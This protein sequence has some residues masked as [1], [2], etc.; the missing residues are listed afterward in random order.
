MIIEI[1]LGVALGLFLYANWRGLLA[2][3]TLISLFLLLLVLAGVTLWALYSGL[4]AVRALPPLLEP[5]SLTST[6]VA[7]VFGVLLNILF[8]FAAGSIIEERLH[9][10]SR[11]AYVLG[12]AFYVLFL[13]SALAISFAVG[14]YLEAKAIETTLL[15]LAL[16]LAA[17]GVGIQQCVRRARNARQRV[18]A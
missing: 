18:A 15:L 7:M 4:Q 1:A 11:E 6:I 12:G 17:W 9:L 2:L 8:A 10:A 5:G 3:G 13:V 14:T 16:L